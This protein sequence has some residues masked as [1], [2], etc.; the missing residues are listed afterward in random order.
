MNHT[1]TKTTWAYIR[2]SAATASLAIDRMKTINKNSLWK[3]GRVRK[4][5]IDN[6][7]RT[8]I[9]M[10]F[11]AVARGEFNRLLV[12]SPDRLS[13]DP[14]KLKKLLRRLEASGVRVQFWGEAPLPFGY[15]YLD[16]AQASRPAR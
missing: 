8:G 14:S 11:R 9:A 15:K 4:I 10:I 12:Q 2:C 3:P 6:E 5:I 1:N 13:R 16:G 7:T